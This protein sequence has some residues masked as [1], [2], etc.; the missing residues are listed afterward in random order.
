MKSNLL[1]GPF[2]D[3][4]PNFE[5]YVDT[6]SSDVLFDFGHETKG[7]EAPFGKAQ[8]VMIYNSDKLKEI[9]SADDLMA[10]AKANPG[11]ITYPAPPD[12][13]DRKSTRLNSSHA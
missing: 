3:K 8:L 4:L 2:V 5:K 1:F 7:Y 12:F 11:K 9:K 6:K 13:T 10:A